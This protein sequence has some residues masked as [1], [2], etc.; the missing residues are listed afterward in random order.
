VAGLA[1][2][3]DQPCRSVG[4]YV[5]SGFRA[6]EEIRRSTQNSQNTQKN[7]SIFL[8]GFRGFCVVRDCFTGSE[9]GHLRSA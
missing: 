4:L 1:A 6:C 2:R 9:A 8:C 5:V 3:F 7:P